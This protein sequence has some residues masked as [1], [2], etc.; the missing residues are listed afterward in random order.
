MKTLNTTFPLAQSANRIAL[1]VGITAGTVSTAEIE[2]HVLHDTIKRKRSKPVVAEGQWYKSITAASY[3]IVSM[4]ASSKRLTKMEYT[5]VVKSEQQRISRL[6]TADCW[7]GF[8]WA[9]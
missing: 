1:L 3:D 9:E 2:S 4:R 8:Y 6:C 5:K 7:E